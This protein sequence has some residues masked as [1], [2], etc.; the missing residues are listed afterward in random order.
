M[1]TF[2]HCTALSLLVASLSLLLAS[3]GVNCFL[4]TGN[5]AS[6]EKHVLFTSSFQFS[7]EFPEDPASN[8]HAEF[9]DLEPIQESSIRMER[10]R[11]DKETSKKFVAYG[12]D[13][14][15]LRSVMNNLSRRLLDAISEGTP[16]EEEKIRSQLREIEQQDP[17]LVYEMELKDLQLAKATGQVDGAELHGENAMEARRCIPAFNLEGLWVGK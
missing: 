1:A 10:K 5:G 9:Q 11:K 17:E 4:V 6:R 14:W 3:K 16:E 7:D 15:R 8:R 13:L 12:D 2:N